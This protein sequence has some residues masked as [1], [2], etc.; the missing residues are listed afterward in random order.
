MSEAPMM[1]GPGYTIQIDESLFSGKRKYIGM[2]IGDKK[3]QADKIR[4]S[5]SQRNYGNRVH[6]PWVFGL[7]CRKISEVEI[8]RK[9]QDENNK[10]IQNEIRRINSNQKKINKDKR[11]L[12]VAS[13]RIYGKN[14]SYKFRLKSKVEHPSK[15]VRMFV[16]DKRD[17]ATLLPI[18]LQHCKPGTEIVSDEWSSYRCLSRNG[19]KHFTVNHGE[20][21]I[22]PVTGKNTQLIEC[23][24]NVAK[25]KIMKSVKGTTRKLLKGYLAEQ[26]YRG[27]NPNQ[28]H[29]IF[30][31]I[32]FLI[33]DHLKNDE[34]ISKVTFN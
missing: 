10:K 8:V 3:N 5:Q 17:K 14:R 19:Y 13:N 28:G 26:W 27:I 11:T 25:Y 1:V 7:V 18:I 4:V 24:W 6:G 12:N 9:T 15:E 30:E 20:N 32:L 16:V 34:R 29:F 2:L 21:F 22:N 23:L 31:K 33:K